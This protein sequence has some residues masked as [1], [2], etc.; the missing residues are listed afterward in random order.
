MDKAFIHTL[1]GIHIL[2]VGNKK[3]FTA[4]AYILFLLDKYTT[5]F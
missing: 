4:K 3:Y 2:G 1:L 5:E